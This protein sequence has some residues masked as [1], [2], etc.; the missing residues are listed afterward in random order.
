MVSSAFIV[1]II[2]SLITLIYIPQKSFFPFNVMKYERRREEGK[3][4]LMNF[5]NW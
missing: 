3:C 1:D 2:S 5:W 4:R